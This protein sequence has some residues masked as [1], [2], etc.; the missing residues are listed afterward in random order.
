MKP[1]KNKK[2][3]RIN[4][5]IFIEVDEDIPDEVAIKRFN[6]NINTARNY[7][8]FWGKKQIS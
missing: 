1:S 6:K 8:S 2:F 5:K 7:T 3:V 4:A